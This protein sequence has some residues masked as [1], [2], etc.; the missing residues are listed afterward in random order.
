M[1]KSLCRAL[2]GVLFLLNGLAEAAVQSLYLP[3]GQEVVVGPGRPPG[4][5]RGFCTDHDLGPPSRE[6]Q[7]WLFIGDSTLETAGGESG[8]TATRTAE[9]V[10]SGW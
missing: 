2:V 7:D 5:I 8:S 1:M 10:A 3:S 9:P 4:R 6:D